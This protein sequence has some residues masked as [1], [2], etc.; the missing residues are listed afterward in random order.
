[1]PHVG[2]AE[3]HIG[4]AMYE[5]AKKLKTEAIYSFGEELGLKHSEINS[6]IRRY[7][8]QGLAIAA[9]WSLSDLQPTNLQALT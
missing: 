7:V 2:P 9:F 4:Y 1:M 6:I 5:I 8:K 3:D